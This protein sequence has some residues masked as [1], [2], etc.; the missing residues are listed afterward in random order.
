MRLALLLPLIA[1]FLVPSAD[2]AAKVERSDEAVARDLKDC[3]PATYAAALDCLDK[4]LPERNQA[5]L[6]APNG[7]IEAHF[8]LG[9]F[10]RNNWGLWRGGRLYEA[11]KAMGFTHPDDMSGAILDGFAARERGE[12]YQAV[13][14]DPAVLQAQWDQAVKEGRAGSFQCEPPPKPAKNMSKKK[15]AAAEIMDCLDQM[16]DSLKGDQE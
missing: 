11:M 16:A 1:A 12:P 13:P 15:Q 7:T 8:G 14:P 3:A 6:A 4:F 9:M 10:L 5:A 2:A